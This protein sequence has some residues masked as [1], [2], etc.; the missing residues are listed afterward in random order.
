M[1][2]A[3]SYIIR[4]CTRSSDRALGAADAARAGGRVPPRARALP[5]F[6]FSCGTY[7]CFVCVWCGIFL[8]EKRLLQAQALQQK[9]QRAHVSKQEDCSQQ[10]QLLHHFAT[11]REAEEF[12]G[13]TETQTEDRATSGCAMRTGYVEIGSNRTSG[14]ARGE[15]GERLPPLETPENLQRTKNSPRLSQES[16]HLLITRFTPHYKIH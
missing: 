14:V 12:R 8:F 2:Y 7:G 4:V 5:V 6:I 15:P 10:P 13:A 16:Y 3:Y 9:L 11:L 1:L